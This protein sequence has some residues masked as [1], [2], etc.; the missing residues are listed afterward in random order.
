MARTGTKKTLVTE[1]AIKMIQAAEA[2]CKKIGKPMCAAIVDDGG[3]LKAF[4]RMD[5]APLLSVGISQLK[6]KTCAGIPMPTHELWNMVKDDQMLVT[7]L[8]AA[9]GV[10]V[11]GGGYP[12][13]VDGECIGGIGLSGASYTEDMQAA[14]AALAVLK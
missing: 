6:A 10:T 2:E 11:L 9:P 1:T 14:E 12:I 8:S 3:N 4:L 7:G 13:M 5:G